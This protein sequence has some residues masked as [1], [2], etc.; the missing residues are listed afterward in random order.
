[1]TKIVLLIL[2]LALTIFPQF[3]MADEVREKSGAVPKVSQ[4]ENSP[5]HNGPS[6]EVQSPVKKN[7]ALVRELYKKSGLKRQ[8]ELFPVS[9][10]VMFDTARQRDQKMKE[11]PEDLV[12]TMRNTIG[13]AFAE[14]GLRDIVLKELGERL[15]A[16]EIKGTLSW[17]DSPLGRRITLMEEASSSPEGFFGMQQY[18]LKLRDSP[19]SADRLKLASRL[20]SATSGTESG[21]E[22]I[23]ST[24]AAIAMALFS[25]LPPGRERPFEDVLREM[26]KTKPYI[27]AAVRSQTQ[28]SILYTYKDL[29]DAEMEQ[30]IGFLTA[31]PGSKYH[32]AVTAAIKKAFVTGSV[33]WGEAIANVAKGKKDRSGA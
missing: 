30:Y 2:S 33:K 6:P 19:P 26:E 32:S 25:A 5:G 1:M 11:L 16:P 3:L 4:G 24:Q 7:D 21:I 18:A 9:S 14:E 22:M 20:D 27:E 28:T 12:S 15:A 8:L 29:T 13:P 17:L 31:P 23:L 10:Q